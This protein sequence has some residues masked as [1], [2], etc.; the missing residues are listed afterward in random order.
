MQLQTKSFGKPLTQN[1]FYRGYEGS[2]YPRGAVLKLLMNLSAI[3]AE[4][5]SR[6]GNDIQ[7]KIECED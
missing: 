6:V 3:F 4:H 5:K 2:L 7:H 1:I